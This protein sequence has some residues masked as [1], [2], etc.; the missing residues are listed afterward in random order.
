MKN[1]PWKQ[2]AA[3]YNKSPNWYKP[4]E[5]AY[6]LSFTNQKVL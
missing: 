3:C 1:K 5:Y 2:M 4:E 6:Q